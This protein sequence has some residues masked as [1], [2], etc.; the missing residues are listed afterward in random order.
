MR[1]VPALG[2]AF[3]A[4]FASYVGMYGYKAVIRALEM[5]NF[6]L[7]AR[8][9]GRPPI[10]D[11]ERIKRM[12]YHLFNDPDLVERNRAGDARH[13]SEAA[14]RAIRDLPRDGD[15]EPNGTPYERAVDRLVAKFGFSWDMHSRGWDES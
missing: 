12:E 8:T 10:D 4:E 1:S 15:V 14:R 6:Q 11:A 2:E 3:L 9:G 7:G 13:L 5:R